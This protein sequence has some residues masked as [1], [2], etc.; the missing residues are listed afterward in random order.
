MTRK[1]GKD[2]GKAGG[3]AGWQVGMQGSR[4]EVKGCSSRAVQQ[5]CACCRVVWSPCILACSISIWAAPLHSWLPACT[6]AH[7]LRCCLPTCAPIPSHYA[8]CKP[9]HPTARN[10]AIILAMRA[11]ALVLAYVMDSLVILF[12]WYLMRLYGIWWQSC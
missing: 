5:A 10:A 1:V 7:S 9:T 11:V 6:P 12:V 2:R 4:L 3:N 8:F